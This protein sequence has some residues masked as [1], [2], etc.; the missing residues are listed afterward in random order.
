MG[1][2]YPE[3][4]PVHLM[5]VEAAE[6]IKKDTNGKVEIGVYG[7]SALGGDTR[8]TFRAIGWMNG[9]QRPE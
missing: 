8:A 7:N 9:S 3:N 5:A 4:L 2:P 6:K 1:H